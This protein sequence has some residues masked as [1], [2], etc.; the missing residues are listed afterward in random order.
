MTKQ[1]VKNHIL[2]LYKV[3][4]ELL[5]KF[6]TGGSLASFPI[7]ISL[8]AIDS[9]PFNVKITLN[10]SL[11]IFCITLIFQLFAFKYSASGCENYLSEEYDDIIKA[12][13]LTDKA[14]GLNKLRDVFFALAFLIFIIAIL[15]NLYELM[16]ENDMTKRE[17]QNSVP[18][19]QSHQKSL[20]PAK[21]LA[22]K[23]KPSLPQTPV[24][25]DSAKNGK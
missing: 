7:I 19:T 8:L 1:E 24:G 22:D 13:R 21:P 14:R 18:V 23:I 3:N 9:I 10:F 15:L 2:D 20:T 11:L 17:K 25:N 4:V 6:I 5:T 16:K 12:G